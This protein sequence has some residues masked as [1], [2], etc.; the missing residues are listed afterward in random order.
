MENIP[1]ATYATYAQL[2][3]IY[4]YVPDLFYETSTCYQITVASETVFLSATTTV[5]YTDI[6]LC[7]QELFK[8]ANRAYSW[9]IS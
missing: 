8:H 5:R 4:M 9:C 2:K 1:P 7:E 3:Q 6:D